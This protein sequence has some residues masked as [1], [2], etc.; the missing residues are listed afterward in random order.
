MS[1]GIANYL[2]GRL[3]DAHVS[4][5]WHGILTEMGM[6]IIS[7][8]PAVGGISY[9]FNEAGEP[10]GEGSSSLMRSFPRFA[11]DL[12]WRTEAARA[13]RARPDPL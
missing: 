12:A 4:V 11:D 6:V 8:T 1:A 13:Q 2:A 5:A 10:I 9:A 3:A 7:G